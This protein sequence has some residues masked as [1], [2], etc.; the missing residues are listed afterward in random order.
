MS[1]KL[2]I[3][4]IWS[5]RNSV[6]TMKIRLGW[7]LRVS[8][9]IFRK[10]V[11]FIPWLC[12]CIF[13]TPLVSGTHLWVWKFIRT[14]HWG[15]TRRFCKNVNLSSWELNCTFRVLKYHKLSF[16]YKNYP[17]SNTEVLQVN[18]S[19]SVHVIHWPCNGIFW[20][21]LSSETH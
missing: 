16:D 9:P 10:S 17:R 20:G 6:L 4:G 14:D 8:K 18:F 13:G 11:N 7:I 3:W 5:I 1:L 21:L 2:H 12:D 15:S 19:K